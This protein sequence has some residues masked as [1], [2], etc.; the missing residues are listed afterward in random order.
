MKAITALYFLSSQERVPVDVR[1]M[2][3]VVFV[4]LLW[5]ETVS[6]NQEYLSLENGKLSPTLSS[7]ARP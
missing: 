1:G 5:P 3:S 6:D 7:R 4:H 2:E